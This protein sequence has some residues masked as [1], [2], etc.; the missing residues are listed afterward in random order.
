MSDFNAHGTVEY[1]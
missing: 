1:H